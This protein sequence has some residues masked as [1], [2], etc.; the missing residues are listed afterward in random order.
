M[1]YSLYL[2]RHL[3]LQL[4]EHLQQIEV[5]I[6]T[7]ALSWSLLKKYS[8]ALSGFIKRELVYVSILIIEEFHEL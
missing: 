6:I 8:K 3:Q 1:L 4:I 2:Y 7:L 5:S